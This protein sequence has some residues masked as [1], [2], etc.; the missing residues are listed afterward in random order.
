MPAVIA[1]STVKNNLFRAN[2]CELK[3]QRGVKT[4]GRG[5][6]PVNK[7]GLANPDG[8]AG[9]SGAPPLLLDPLRVFT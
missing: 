9:Q 1:I 4:I 8:V 5:K 7:C 2:I 3:P 6:A